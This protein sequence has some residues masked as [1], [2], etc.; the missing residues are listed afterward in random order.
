MDLILS[1]FKLPGDS[2]EVIG[3]H[4]RVVAWGISSVLSAK[5][6]CLSID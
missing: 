1:A 2:G 5:N 6:V 3:K 4:Q